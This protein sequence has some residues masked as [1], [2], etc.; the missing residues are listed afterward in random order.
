MSE[1][2]R[3]DEFHEPDFEMGVVEGDETRNRPAMGATFAESTQE[4]DLDW[5][6]SSAATDFLGIDADV[7]GDGASAPLGSLGTSGLPADSWLHGIEA[8]TEV[9]ATAAAETDESEPE[10]DEDEQ[11]EGKR[12]KV[13]E[14]KPGSFLPKLVAAVFVLAL[15]A[16]GA[17]YWKT[18]HA[19]QKQPT[20][21]ATKPTKPVTKKPVP[22][23]KT[24]PGAVVETPTK[25]GPLDP[26]P[27]PGAVVHDAP[28]T[29][30]EPQPAQPE[31]VV[32]VTPTVTFP[33]VPV[34]DPAAVTTPPAPVTSPE[35]VTQPTNTRVP[36]P[37]DTPIPGAVRRATT[38]TC[39]ANNPSRSRRSRANSGCA[40]S[41]LGRCA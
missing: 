33:D 5:K 8:H 11:S 13:S 22:P 23:T 31:P 32:A 17:W 1:R 3:N 26:N 12:Q 37:S 4:L 21:V 30:T 29:P 36:P 6:G 25:P 40:R 9:P 24:T 38:P 20:E 34:T 39:G 28:P 35:P 18:Q 16:G 19:P 15:A 27:D 2:D 14:P 10:T 7:R 41:T